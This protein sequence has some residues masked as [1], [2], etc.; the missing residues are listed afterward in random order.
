MILKAC[1][2]VLTSNATL[3]SLVG[4]F[5]STRMPSLKAVVIKND[6]FSHWHSLQLATGGGKVAEGLES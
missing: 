5:F 4:T 2:D 3:V 6:T 1:T